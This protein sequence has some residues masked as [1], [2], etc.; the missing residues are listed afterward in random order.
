MWCCSALV[1]LGHAQARLISDQPWGQGC[2]LFLYLSLPVW[3]Y[4]FP[5]LCNWNSSTLHSGAAPQ[6][7]SSKLLRWFFADG[8]SYEKEAMESWISTNRRSSPMTNLP[9]PSLLLTPNRTLKMAIGRWLEARPKHDWRC[10]V[11]SAEMKSRVAKGN[12]AIRNNWKGK[13]VFLICGCHWNV[14]WKE[15]LH[16]WTFLENYWK[17]FNVSADFSLCYFCLRNEVFS[18]I[19]FPVKFP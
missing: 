10:V 2:L 8:Y 7:L 16:L 12:N 15:N 3:K 5:H 6:P 19:L 4:R 11:K 18:F 14:C 9:L 1:Y 17:A 13:I